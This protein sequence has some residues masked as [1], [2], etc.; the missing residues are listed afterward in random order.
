MTIGLIIS[1]FA[2]M[3]FFIAST[4]KSDIENLYKEEM[5]S[6]YRNYALPIPTHITFAG[7]IVPV[8]RLDVR[9]SLD[10]EL[11]VNTYWHSQ[12]FLF[13]K[14]AHRYF[15]IIEPILEEKDIHDDFKY[16]ALIESGL[17]N[18]VSPAG[19][20][21]VWQFMKAT[22][23]R[24][25]LFM[26][27]E[28]DERYHLEKATRAACRYLHHSYSLFNSWTLAAAAY[29]M[30]DAGL[31][32]QLN[33]QNVT[34]YYDLHLNQETARYMFRILAVKTIFENPQKYGFYFRERDLYPPVRTHVL[35]V[36]TTISNLPQFALDN[37]INMKLLRI[38]NPW[39]RSNSLTSRAGKEFEIRIP[40]QEDLIYT[41]HFPIPETEK[42][43]VFFETE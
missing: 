24:H 37:G 40:Y 4:L 25:G 42:D 39:I 36:D 10:R 15:P 20:A 27:N 22:A 11:L 13:F 17:A 12:T 18:V 1:A 6:Y 41:K 29:N 14:R 35:T 28:V 32:R 2:L 21:G 23:E 33:N 3:Y 16:L 7:E 9:E 30:G 8:N 19:A 5:K 38:Y 31:R 26:N 43:T 34:S